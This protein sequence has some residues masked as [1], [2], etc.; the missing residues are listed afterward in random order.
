MCSG[1][2]T[3][4]APDAN[5]RVVREQQYVADKRR[6]ADAERGGRA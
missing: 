6:Q 3:E 2:K 1:Q 4:N 5:R